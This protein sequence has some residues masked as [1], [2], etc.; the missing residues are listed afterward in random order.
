MPKEDA[1]FNRELV[2]AI[3]QHPCLYDNTS[4]DY[5]VRVEVYKA[6]EEVASQVNESGNVL[7]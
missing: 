1:T 3:R 6:W 7:L 4:C 2:R 5:N